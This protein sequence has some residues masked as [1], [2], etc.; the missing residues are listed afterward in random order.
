[1]ASKTGTIRSLLFLLFFTAPCIIFLFFAP[2]VAFALDPS[3]IAW[4]TLSRDQGFVGGAV[5]SIVQ[6]NRGL[7]WIGA[8]NGLYRYDGQ[9]FTAF[10]PETWSSVFGVPLIH[11]LIVDNQNNIWIGTSDG[12]LCYNTLTGKFRKAKLLKPPGARSLKIVALALNQSMGI[13]A[14]ALDGTL[15][16][17]DLSTLEA[18]IFIKPGPSEEPIRALM[19]DAKGR[20]WVSVEGGGLILIDKNGSLLA[21]FQHKVGDES[22]PAS[23]SVSALMED[24]LGYIWIGYTDGGLDLYEEGLFRHAV[25]YNPE[26]G[27]SMAQKNL[28]A[29]SALAEDIQGQI[30]VGLR[31]GGIGILDPSSMELAVYPF[32]S[33]SEVTAL[34]RDRRGLLWAGLG[35]GGLLTGDFRSMSFE[36]FT[37][38]GAG[39]ELGAV[40]A[41]AET[42]SGR[43][44]VASSASGLVAFDMLSGKFIAQNDR[45]GSV[46]KIQTILPLGDGS[47]WLGTSGSGLIGRDANG[48]YHRITRM[49]IGGP[50]KAP[51]DAHS[52][53]SPFVLCVSSAVGGKLWVGTEGG[54]L[55]LVDPRTETV[56]H[57]GYGAN[58]PPRLPAATITCILHDGDGRIWAGSADSGLFVLE[59]GA[60]RFREFGRGNRSSEGLG[61][62]HINALLRDS[63][64]WLWVGLGGGGLVAIDPKAEVILK[65]ATSAG[66]DD[67]TIYGIAEDRAGILWVAGSQGFYS[68]DTQRGEVFRFGSEDGLCFGGYEA[69]VIFASPRGDLW[70]GSEGGITRFNPLRIARYEPTPDVIIADVESLDRSGGLRPP[71]GRE[72]RLDYNN[73]GLS[74]S[75]AVIDFAASKRNQYAMKLEGMQFDWSDMG[76][77]NVGYIAPL[78][79]GHY[80][81]RVKAANGNGIWNQYGASL[82]IVVNPPW[83][84]TWWFRAVVV[85]TCVL[86]IAGAVAASLRSLRRRNELL[87]RF[88]RHIEEARE[89]ERTIVARDVHDEIGQ[90]LMVL[91]FHAYW[92]STN[93]EAVAAERR[94]VVDQLQKG[95][96][97]AM[98]SVKVVATRLRPVGLDALDFPDVLRYYMRSFSRMSGIKTSLDVEPGWNTMPPETAKVFFRLLQEML[99]NVARHSKAKQA[100]VRFSDEG[101]TFLL[102]VEDDGVGIEAEK[103]GAQDSFGIIGMRESCTSRGGALFFVPSVGGGCTVRARLPKSAANNVE[104]SRGRRRPT[105]LIRLIKKVRKK[106][107]D[108]TRR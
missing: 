71:D 88:A 26:Q 107:V 63:R 9:G 75:I 82:P 81:L 39:G 32:A 74:F 66:L 97:D 51:G 60:S 61:S 96:L 47:I 31:E 1:M 19:T 68:F 53:A 84:G 54:G 6:D 12:V 64:G 35:R 52:L 37:R 33:G 93:L 17:I 22:S 30:W 86:L 99:S 36:R 45:L 4:R 62:Q 18:T 92:L 20:I 15:W 21:S 38:T 85:G 59:P 70:L 103:V 27:H 95:I 49:G 14:G 101:A 48:T 46:K 65:R 56:E 41:M 40:S 100:S 80:M 3:S 28:P 42:A 69:G 91:N 11:R 23:N 73:R 2:T 43:T 24:S 104:C 10:K 94:S 7:I 83:W 105:F 5:F 87:A 76:S 58:Q 89:E 78:S 98:N 108:H 106:N 90:H 25:L 13:L 102:E 29:V 79:P 55:D 34:L 8:E 67:D 50:G 57:W 44:L 72:I 77:L 16:S